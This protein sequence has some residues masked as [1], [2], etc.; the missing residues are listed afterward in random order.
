MNCGCSHCKITFNKKSA[1][2]ISSFYY[3]LIYNGDQALITN[4]ILILESDK[5]HHLAG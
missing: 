5:S 4:Q 1:S 2:N 3:V